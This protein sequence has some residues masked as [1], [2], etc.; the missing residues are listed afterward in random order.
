MIRAAAT[1][2]ASFLLIQSVNAQEHHWP[3]NEEQ[4]QAAKPY[5]D[6]MRAKAEQIDDGKSDI[7]TIGWQVAL[8]C[9]PQ[10]DQM[11]NQLGLTLSPEDKDALRKNEMNMRVGFGAV[12]VQR[13]RLERGGQPVANP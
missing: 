5:Q 10:F 9:Q 7:A 1:L 13:V 8:A 12:A 11:I 6:C 4:E 2:V 3:T